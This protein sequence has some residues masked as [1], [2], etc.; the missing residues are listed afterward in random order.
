M[1][2]KEFFGIAVM[3]N[4]SQNNKRDQATHK[5]QPHLFLTFYF[6]LAYPQRFNFI[7]QTVYLF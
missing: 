1:N 6:A 7:L 4:S 3:I 2:D 5:K